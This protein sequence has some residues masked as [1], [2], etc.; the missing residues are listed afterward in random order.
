MKKPPLLNISYKILPKLINRYT[1]NLMKVTK[2][3][4]ES[5][6]IDQNQAKEVQIKRVI[7]GSKLKFY[8]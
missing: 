5:R 3:Q 7:K 6:G 4:L 2:G 8:N 1:Q